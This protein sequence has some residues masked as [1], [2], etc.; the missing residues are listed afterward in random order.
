MVLDGLTDQAVQFSPPPR[1][2][3]DNKT[4]LFRSAI[5]AATLSGFLFPSMTELDGFYR[6]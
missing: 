2:K 3:T 6:L 1:E 5:E 4:D